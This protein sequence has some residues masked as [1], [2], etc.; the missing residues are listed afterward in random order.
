VVTS[1][2]TTHA[3]KLGLSQ[4]RGHG[5]GAGAGE[6]RWC[7]LSGNRARRLGRLGYAPGLSWD[8]AREMEA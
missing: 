8:S 6:Q 2:G 5:T 4:S 3:P 7:S 1:P